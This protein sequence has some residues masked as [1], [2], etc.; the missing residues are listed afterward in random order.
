MAQVKIR[1]LNVSPGHNFFGHHGQPPGENPMRS[2]LEIECLAGRGIC[3]D[4]FLDY[5]ENYKGQITFFDFE[6]FDA[7]F[8]ELAVR[9]KP[10]SV[11][12]RNVITEGVQGLVSAEVWE[13]CNQLIDESYCKQRR[14]GKK[15]VHIFAGVAHCECGQRMYVPSNSP[16]YICRACRNKITIADLDAIFCEKIK[17]YS[18]SPEAIAAYL[19]TA[20][21]TARE[22]ERLLAVQQEE[23]KRVQKEIQRTYDLY[24][25]EK[26]DA[27][28]FSAFYNPLVERKKQMEVGLPR[29]QAEVDVLKVIAFQP[30][31]LPPRQAAFMT[32]GKQCRGKKRGK[33]L[34]LSPTDHHCQRRNHHKPL[35][36]AFL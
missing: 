29:L 20:D 13:Q 24:Q 31:K 2:A 23:L 33:S 1:R 19:H 12:R 7:I 16:K 28:G 27:D 3:D 10:P 6:V 36:H 21:N 25:Q 8:R 14:P 11:F 15:P 5:K 17:G 26:L 34:K 9:D 35:L 22:K 32:T 4:C 30:R 18:L